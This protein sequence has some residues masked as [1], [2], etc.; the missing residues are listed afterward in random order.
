MMRRYFA[1]VRRSGFDIGVS[2]GELTKGMV[3]ALSQFAPDTPLSKE[4]VAG[5]LGILGQMSKTR[6]INA[7]WDR[8]KRQVAREQPDRFCLDGKVL[9]WASALENRSRE[10]LSSTGHRK[11]TAMAAKEGISPDEFLKRLIASRR[12]GRR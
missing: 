2:T 1:D 12:V 9:R 11:L 7:A 3:A 4:V 5:S 8:A 10:K 6:D